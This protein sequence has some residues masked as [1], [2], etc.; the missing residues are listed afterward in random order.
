MFINNQRIKNIVTRNYKKLYVIN[1][2][3]EIRVSK[4]K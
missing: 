2:H 3:T 1:G 4:E